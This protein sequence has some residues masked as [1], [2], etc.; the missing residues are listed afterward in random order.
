MEHKK[1]LITG[2]NGFIGS[3]LLKQLL[4]DN[5]HVRAIV[6][7]NGF[8]GRAD[9]VYLNITPNIDWSDYL[10]DVRVVIHVA[11]LAHIFNK[12][13]ENSL[14]NYRIENVESTLNLARYSAKLGVTRFIYISSIKV[15]GDQ[16]THGIKYSNNS[17][18]NPKDN[19]GISKMEAEIGL[20]EIAK[21]T[22]LELVIIRPP[23]VYG[24][25]VKGNFHRLMKLASIGL[26]LPVLSFNNK[27]SIVSIRNLVDFIILCINSKDASNKILMVSDGEDISVLDLIKK[28]H[29]Y[30]GHNLLVFPVP[31]F[32]LRVIFKF[33][34]KERE[35]LSLTN[36]MEI[37]VEN[38][39]AVLNWAPKV[40]LDAGLKDMVENYIRL[41]KK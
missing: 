10:I 11:G 2:A 14:K 27:R 25:N 6:R 23:L 21:I 36:S 9:I 38:S 30:F 16:T 37:D 39:K 34:G 31:F 20:I 12:D 18:Y 7:K 26:P 24:P 41:H 3:A 19:Y 29:F 17:P 15:L 1:I 35:F 8:I 5:F 28:L 32:I 13:S 4:H 40:D 22:Q 33:I